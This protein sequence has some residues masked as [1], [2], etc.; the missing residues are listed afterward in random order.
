M[1][2]I[3]TSIL[4]KMGSHTSSDKEKQG[5]AILV[6]EV[7]Q[8][9]TPPANDKAIEPID[10]PVNSKKELTM[11]EALSCTAFEFP[12][13]KKWMILSVIFII[14]CSMNLNASIYG[15]AVTGLKA[16]F[17]IDSQMA[18]TGQAVFLI[19]YGFGCELWAPWSEEVR[20]AETCGSSLANEHLVGSKTRHAILAP[21]CQH[22]PDP[23][24]SRQRL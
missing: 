5:P 3:L 7:S 18:R 16:E 20:I 23:V 13:R 4:E 6:D 24:R 2:R 14:Q 19:A 12:E 10:P 15:N 22:L 9:N 8:P 11:A 21:F 17:G 1:R